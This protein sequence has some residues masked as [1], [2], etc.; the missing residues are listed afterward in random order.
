MSQKGTQFSHGSLFSGIG[1]FDLAAEWMGW[2]NIFHC[3]I[4]PFCKRILKYY[5][6]NAI[7]YEDITKTDFTIHRGTIDVLSGGFPCQP[8]ST[9]GKRRGKD[10]SRHLWP[11]MLRAI[12]E[13]QPSYVVGENVRGLINWNG[14][15]VFD[16]VQSDL[17]T[18]GYEVAPFLLP[19]CAVNAPHRRER[20]WFIAYNPN[21][22]IESLQ[23]R[24]ENGI[25][26]PEFI[27]HTASQLQQ[28]NEPRKCG[29]ER[30]E[31]IQQKH[32]EA[33][34]KQPRTM[35][36]NGNV[37][38]TENV[39]FQG[40]IET[41][42]GERQEPNDKQFNGCNRKRVNAWE[43]FPTQSPICRR[44]DGFSSRLDGITFSKWRNESIKAF[45]NAVVPYL[46]YQIFN[47]INLHSHD[48]RI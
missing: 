20:I 18:F 35:G 16:E 12:R 7:S 10:D 33:N 43:Q 13:I 45:G 41:N 36:E 28:G 29:T 17:E 1:G 9:A 4:N 40:S 24:R 2:K 46:P 14:G 5:W 32:W 44:N 23:Y 22:R 19:A 48:T 6:P 27:A 39:G 47:A 30:R 3:E 42:G 8:F 25:Y 15:M 37:T 11:E 38:N 34:T 26:E 21:A 31:I